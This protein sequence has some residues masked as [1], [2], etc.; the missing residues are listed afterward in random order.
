MNQFL[1]VYDVELITKGPLF[2]GSGEEIKKKEYFYDKKNKKIIIPKRH[3]LYSSLSSMRLENAFEEYIMDPNDRR[4]L[5]V[6]MSNNKVN[7]EVI[8]E[9]TN[10]RLDCGD[11]MLDDKK[12]SR[13]QL[14]AC[15][16][17][18]YGCPYVPGSTLKGLLRTI[19]LTELVKDNN[20]CVNEKKELL[21]WSLAPLYNKY[22]RN[23]DTKRIGKVTE[24]IEKK[25]LTTKEKD[26]VE[27][28]KEYDL[29]SGLVVSDSDALSTDDLTVCQKVDLNISGKENRLPLLRECIKPGTKIK[30]RI[31]IDNSVLKID[32][33]Y[34]EKAIAHFNEMVNNILVSKFEFKD[35]RSSSLIWLGGG[36][37]YI[38]KTI[39]YQ[40]LGDRSVDFVSKMFDE[41]LF[42]NK[43]EKPK[44]IND[45]RYGVSPHT[46][47]ITY[48]KGR[49]YQF[50]LCD[51]KLIETI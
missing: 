39:T 48:Y 1:K 3:K 22:D 23:N 2:V 9:C 4:G 13:M 49:K 18:A 47:K 21:N 14:M 7:R 46:L 31:T 29:L 20:S 32:K 34:I 6:W 30:F 42:C 38:S 33:E 45:R 26:G 12:K 43:K 24:K 50:G 35:S 44:H 36:S 19:I 16:K 15:I 37:G 10:Y 27:L 40:M 41:R 11:V 25:I 8:K 51:I 17:D 28:E 5:D